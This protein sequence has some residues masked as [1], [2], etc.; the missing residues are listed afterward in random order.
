MGRDSESHGEHME[1]KP[2]FWGPVL[3]G[4]LTACFD[5]A[6]IPV[7]T[8]SPPTSAGR[9][10]SEDSST[11]STESTPDEDLGADEDLGSGPDVGLVERPELHSPD[12]AEDLDPAEDQV[13]IKLTASK[14][15]FEAAGE[16]VEGYAYNKQVPGPTI[17]VP[18]GATVTIDFKNDLEVPTTVHWHG[19]HVPFAMDGVTWQGSPVEAGETFIYTFTLN[20]TGTYWY[21]PHFDTERQADLG[22]YGVLIV[23]DPEDA[24]VDE[25]LVV[26]LDSWGEYGADHSEDS[27]HDGLDGVNLT[28]TANGLLDPV[29][30]PASGARTRVRV[31]NVSNSGYADLRWPSMRHIAS[32]QG[33]LPELNEPENIVLAP[34]DRMDGE[35]LLDGNPFDLRL[36]PYTLVGLA[37]PPDPH[38]PDYRLLSVEPSG[39]ES[40]PVPGE[41]PFDGAEP[42][43]DPAYTDIVYTFQGDPLTG[44]WLINGESFPDVTIEEAPLG[45]DSII[46]IRNISQSEH[47]FHLH[48]H[49]F[50][51]LSYDGLQPPFRVMEDSINVRVGE[52]VRLRLFANN[53]GDWMTHCHILPHVEGGMM[54]V[55]RVTGP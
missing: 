15:S 9:D 35:W 48:G 53:P 26:V 54:T 18:L 11:G 23:E 12:E 24:P 27:N 6:P 43:L 51:V 42:T 25:E 44:D 47:P 33:L 8:N 36:A 17:R 39:D 28:W 40:A 45:E 38:N 37:T 19:L 55:L 1:V 29:Y 4:L 16:L 49:A 13:H 52:T 5:T 2:I 46:E 20:Q 32:D 41:W 10:S 34:S 3:S 22:L 50:E 30:K 31:V 7:N 21:H 14:H